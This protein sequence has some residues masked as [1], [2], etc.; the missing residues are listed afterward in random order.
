MSQS[1]IRMIIMNIRF[2]YFFYFR[3]IMLFSYVWKLLSLQTTIV[4]G[5][6]LLWI[7]TVNVS[8][9]GAAIIIEALHSISI[10]KQVLPLCLAFVTR[11]SIVFFHDDWVYSVKK[12]SVG[13][14]AIITKW[15]ICYVILLASKN[16]IFQRFGCVSLSVP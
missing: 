6:R 5:F 12:M 11:V 1:A 15:T 3:L 13:D 2:I 10:G 7:A 14:A 16:T 9:G 8:L 4:I